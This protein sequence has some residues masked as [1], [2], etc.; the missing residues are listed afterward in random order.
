MDAQTVFKELFEKYVL[1]GDHA[2]SDY[3]GLI[4]SLLKHK[5][6]FSITAFLETVYDLLQDEIRTNNNAPLTSVTFGTS[7]WRGKLGKDVNVRTASA[8][9]QAIVNLYHQAEENIHLQ[10]LLGVASFAEAKE[11]GCVLGFDNRFAGPLLA[12]S[13]ASVLQENRIKVHYA[14]ETTTGVLSAAV[15]ELGAAFSINLTPSHN[16]L[17]YG[18][19]KYNAADAGPAEAALTQKITDNTRALL[20][21]AQCNDVP[22]IS[23]AFMQSLE[24]VRFDS[25]AIWK[26]FVQKNRQV[27]TLDYEN[28]FTEFGKR[29]DIAVVIDSLHGASRVHVADLFTYGGNVELLRGESDVTFGGIAP[30]PSSVNM[31]HVVQSLADK[32]EQFKLGAIIDPD[33]DRI[34]FTDGRTEISMNQFGA[35]AYHFLHEVRHLSG[36]AAKTVASSNLANCLASTFGE[37]VFEPRVGFKEFKPVLGK[38]LV[39]F[40]ESDGIS[41]IGHT[42]EKDAYIGLLLALDMVMTTGKNL[43]EYLRDIEQEFGSFYPDRDGV[44]VS[45]QGSDLKAALSKLS[46]YSTGVEVRVGAENK[47]ISELITIDGIKMIFEDASWLMI[48]PSGTE[49]KVRFYVESRDKKGTSDLVETAKKML[50]DIGLIQ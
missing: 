25:L 8:V 21:S 13:A 41:V 3:F 38:A 2:R 4:Y 5:H 12:A 11:R 46:T 33:G 20:D 47:K 39:C 35:M 15:L 18:G 27:H 45:V 34:R 42:P 30:E 31:Q 26:G 43:G 7:G 19:F 10:K 44:E 1:P 36:M 49:S 48:R 9:T 32:T 14:G 6:A 37:Q 29:D 40:E 50:R 28:V 17:E 22:E 24:Q 23:D 16:P